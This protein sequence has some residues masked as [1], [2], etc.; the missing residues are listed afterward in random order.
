VITT[1]RAS[2]QRQLVRK[3]GLRNGLL[4]GLALALGAL[5]PRVITVSRAHVQGAY[6]ALLLGLLALLLLGGVAGWLSAW[7]GSAL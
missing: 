3:L 2:T 7:P 5:A 1:E 6:L 4:I